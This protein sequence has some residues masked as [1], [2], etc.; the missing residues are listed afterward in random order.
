VRDISGKGAEASYFRKRT[1]RLYT[2]CATVALAVV[3]S[4][5]LAID[6]DPKKQL[7]DN[8][9]VLGA[10]AFY[11]ALG[12]TA[13]SLILPF[14]LIPRQ[15]PEESALPD[16]DR[17]AF[18]Y[19]L[20]NSFIKILRLCVFSV[21]ILQGVV[22]AVSILLN[23][24]K[25]Y[26]PTPVTYVMLLLVTPLAMYFVPEVTERIK[27]ANGRA[28]MIFG[29]VG[30]IWFI[31]NVLE[32]YFDKSVSLASEYITLTQ[33][34][35]IVTMLALVYEMR[36]H[37]DGTKLR[38]RLATSCA[39]CVLGIGFGFAQLVMLVSVGQVSF[40]ATSVGVT[41]LSLGVYFGAR[42]FFYEED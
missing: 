24:E 11:S 20:D 39:A 38:V 32:A 19:T 27:A 35:C 36:Y 14:I 23:V 1:V 33:L 18:Y 12:L 42:I 28:H 8:G 37:L 13:V 5:A 9:S 34:T 6:F 30:L 15:K 4:L 7:F 22:R 40:E 25:A 21:I 41:L 29:S 2:L 26:L 3:T 10:I 16:G 31:L 17:Y